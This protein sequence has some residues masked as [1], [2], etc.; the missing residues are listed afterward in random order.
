MKI[1]RRDW[2]LGAGGLFAATAAFGLTPRNN[3][4][5]MGNARLE[6]FIP[7]KIG[8]W[9]EDPGANVVM[10]PSDGSLADELYDQIFS[11]GYLL[12]GDDHNRP[13]MLFSSHGERQNDAL[14]LHRPETCYPA[15]G[16]VQVARELVDVP[17]GDGVKLP[18]VQLTMQYGDRLEDILYW[19]RIGDDL[20]QTS[21]QQRTDRLREALRGNVM[22]GLLMRLSIAR[23]KASPPAYQELV[24]FAG[25]ML[26][27]VSPKQRPALIGRRYA[28]G[29]AV[30]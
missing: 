11:R 16:F 1:D 27:A 10:P 6:D 7:K 4:N 17:V 2:L 14:Q 21:S 28:S 3:I 22:D 9:S 24:S 25:Q 20:P 30:T 5:L 13:L 12:E 18:A 19:A 23:T 29:L 8:Q 26:H 15:I